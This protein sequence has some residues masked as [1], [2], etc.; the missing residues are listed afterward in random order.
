MPRP[1]SPPPRRPGRPPGRHGSEA[2]GWWYTPGH[3]VGTGRPRGLGGRGSTRILRTP[4]P[5]VRP[6]ANPRGPTWWR[7]WHGRHAVVAAAVTDDA[8]VLVGMSGALAA[9]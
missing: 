7:G 4:P 2:G 5:L 9:G 1:R 3:L 8:V 6:F